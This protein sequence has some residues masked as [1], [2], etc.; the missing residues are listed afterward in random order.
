M[1]LIFLKVIHFK[2]LIRGFICLVNNHSAIN[3]HVQSTVP[4]TEK[5]V[6]DEQD[7]GFH[8]L[9]TEAEK[10]I[11]CHT[12]AHEINASQRFMKTP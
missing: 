7:T 12:K 8:L 6:T 9:Q 4:P 3:H 1:A 11:Q 2:L 5:D 10:Q